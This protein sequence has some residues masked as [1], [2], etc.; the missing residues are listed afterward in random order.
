MPFIR[1]SLAGTPVSNEQVRRLQA[2]TT[3]L[4]AETLG[5]RPEVTVVAVE[6]VPAARW[7]VGG[8]PLR[9]DG[10]LAQME[11]FITRGSNCDEEKSAF[12]SSACD[13][14]V[15]VLGIQASP[16]YVIVQEIPGADWGFDGKTQ[17]A[18]RLA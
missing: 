16:V 1:I 5:K 17:A 11:A 3:A 4:M 9:E 8:S 10:G 14:L 13:M 2:R 18:R 6:S 15:A 7:S 12:I